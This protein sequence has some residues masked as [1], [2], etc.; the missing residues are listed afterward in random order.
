MASIRDSISLC[1]PR[2]LPSV[3]RREVRGGPE[4]FTRKT[5]GTRFSR[6]SWEHDGSART[7]LQQ[8]K[9]ESGG[10][11]HLRERSSSGL[12]WGKPEQRIILPHFS[13]PRSPWGRLHGRDR[14]YLGTYP[15]RAALVRSTEPEGELGKTRGTTPGRSLVREA[16][17]SPSSLR[18]SRVLL[19]GVSWDRVRVRFKA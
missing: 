19:A 14:N 10:S 17:S 9:W 7:P 2:P 6:V 18:T 13:F 5:G 12:D 16:P 3:P 1:D 8:P 15:S 4:C 11:P